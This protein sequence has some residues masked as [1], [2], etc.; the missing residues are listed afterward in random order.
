MMKTAQIISLPLREISLVYSNTPLGGYALEKEGKL[1]HWDHC[2]EQFAVRFDEKVEGF[3]FNHKPDTAEAIAQFIK[4][5][6]LILQKSD[7]CQIPF[8]TEF[9]YTS[10]PNIIYIQLSDFWKDCFFKR[11]LFTLLVRCGQ[12]YTRKP[13]NF[14]EA[15]FGCNFKESTYLLETKNAV[16]R[17]MFGY[18][19]YTGISP[20]IGQG[21]VI[22]H[23]WKE[24]FYKL[25][26]DEIRNRLVLP[27][28]ASKTISLV[29]N[30]SLWS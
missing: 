22:K 5:F 8:F 30:D 20:V 4:K 7:K 18:T 24:E 17:F 1:Q 19:K 26:V 29:G 28:G 25:T 13:D 11:S 2:R 12:N 14:D 23:G 6:E 21:T 15:L 9:A 10:K 16:M 3:Y 27:D